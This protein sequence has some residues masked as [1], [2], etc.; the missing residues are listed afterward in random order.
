[1]IVGGHRWHG[2]QLFE[3]I[4]QVLFDLGAELFDAPFV[5][6]ILHAGVLAILTV[7]K[8]PLNHDNLFDDIN[9]LVKA[10]VAQPLG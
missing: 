6:Q 3:R 4:A 7:T 5:D 8:V 10:N 9:H 1:M 2:A